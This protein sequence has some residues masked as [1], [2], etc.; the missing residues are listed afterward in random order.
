VRQV[1]DPFAVRPLD[2]PQLPV[3]EADRR[4]PLDLVEPARLIADAGE[5]IALRRL[6]TRPMKGASATVAG[7]MLNGSAAPSGKVGI[8]GATP[9]GPPPWET[10]T[11]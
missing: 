1:A 5:E 2:D 7:R 6:A 9:A 8:N 11:S 10:H 3:G 4:V